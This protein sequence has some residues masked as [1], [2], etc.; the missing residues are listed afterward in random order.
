MRAQTQRG[1]NHQPDDKPNLSLNINIIL[2]TQILYRLR[3]H[4][5]LSPRRVFSSLSWLMVHAIAHSVFL[6]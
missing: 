3:A 2:V 4:F 6:G 5:K 1:Q